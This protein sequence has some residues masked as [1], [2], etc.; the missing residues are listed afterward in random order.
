MAV[1]CQSVCIQQIQVPAAAWMQRRGMKLTPRELDHLR[2]SQAGQLAQ[3]RLA[4]GLRL[5][6]PEAVALLTSQMM[7]SGGPNGGKTLGIR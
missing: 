4:R 5:N 6:H 3:R 1:R 7:E 2:L